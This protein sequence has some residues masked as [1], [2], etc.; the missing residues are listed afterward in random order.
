MSIKNQLPGSGYSNERRQREEEWK[1]LVWANNFIKIIGWKFFELKKKDIYLYR[2]RCFGFEA[3]PVVYVGIWKVIQLQYKEQLSWLNMLIY[4]SYVTPAPNIFHM[5]CNILNNLC[6]IPIK[7][8][9]TLSTA[10][11]VNE[12][13][14]F[15]DNF[16][17]TVLYSFRKFA[18]SSPY[19]TGL[20]QADETPTR[21]HT[22]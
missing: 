22:R 19:S 12:K 20:V 4:I 2:E 15:L 14:C 7:I 3:F 13:Q 21:W 8:V 10:A 6:F 17:I 11:T 18:L 5:S 9:Y 1:C 16:S